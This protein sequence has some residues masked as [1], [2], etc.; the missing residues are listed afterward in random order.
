[1]TPKDPVDAFPTFDT[2]EKI[3]GSALKTCEKVVAGISLQDERRKK[4]KQAETWP[5]PQSIRNIQVFLGFRG[6]IGDFIQSKRH[7]P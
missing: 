1:M 6:L 2:R 3:D 7:L 5:K 4:T